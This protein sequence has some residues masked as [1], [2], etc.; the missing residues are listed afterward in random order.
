VIGKPLVEVIYKKLSYQIV[1]A[2]IEVHRSLG[3]GFLENV[4]QT[5]LAH[6]FELQEI[7]FE[8]QKRLT[9]KYKDI[10]AGDYIA[11]FVVEKKIIVEIKAV[12]NLNSSHQAQALNYLAATGYKLAILL[13]FGATSLQQRRVVR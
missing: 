5:S 8:A 4:Y 9:M 1:G 3:S 13:N 10:V 12:S 2:A 7:P 6:E 11:D